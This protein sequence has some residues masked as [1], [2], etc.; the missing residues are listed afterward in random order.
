MKKK[1]KSLSEI[2]LTYHEFNFAKK[3]KVK[4]VLNEKL[5]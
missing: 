3:K 2:K 4:V 1:I 5:F